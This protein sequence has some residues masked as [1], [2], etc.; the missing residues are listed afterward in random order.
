MSE[1]QFFTATAGLTFAEVATA[2]GLALPEG[3]DPERI[4]TGAAPLESAGPHDLAYMDNAR[5]GEAL[6]GTRAGL[7]LVGPRFAARCPAGTV[8]LVCRDPYRVYAGLLGRLHPDAL[9][10]GS[11]FGARGIAPG[12]H[13]HSEARSKRA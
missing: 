11:Q 4:L 13:V 1:T 9:R 2:A 5:Y 8:A 6:A 12:A 3:V 10:P 7:C